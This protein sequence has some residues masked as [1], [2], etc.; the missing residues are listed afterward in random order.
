MP[1]CSSRPQLEARGV[2]PQG[3]SNVVGMPLSMLLRNAGV[4]A[5]TS[6]HRNSYKEL[7]QGAHSADGPQQRAQAQACGPTLPGGSAE[8]GY[9]GGWLSRCWAGATAFRPASDAAGPGRGKGT[10]FCAQ[11][12]CGCVLKPSIVRLQAHGA[13]FVIC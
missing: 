3:D 7:L 2:A 10:V 11:L 8:A 13:R 4:A 5:L 6:C 1:P 9:P 12:L